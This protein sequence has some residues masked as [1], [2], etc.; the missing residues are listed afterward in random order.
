[1]KSLKLLITV[2]TAGFLLAIV[3]GVRK[4]KENTLGSQSKEKGYLMDPN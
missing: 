1:M 4:T 2:F 3:V